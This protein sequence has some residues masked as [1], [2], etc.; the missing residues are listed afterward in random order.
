MNSFSISELQNFSGIKAHTIRIWEQRYAALKPN[1]TDGNTRY[2][3][4]SQ[5]RRLLNIVSLLDT[6]YKVSELCSMPDKKLVKLLDEKLSQSISADHAYEYFISQIVSST[7][8]YNEMQ[9]DKLFISMV[10]RNGLR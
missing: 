5:L 4:G 2:Y 8:Q 9:F 3:N 7:I 1:R 6:D 10:C